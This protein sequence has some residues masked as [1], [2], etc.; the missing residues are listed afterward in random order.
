MDKKKPLFSKTYIK[1]ETGYY[2]SK[3]KPIEIFEIEKPA[4]T[5][6]EY[7]AIANQPL[8]DSKTMATFVEPSISKS[9]YIS[10]CKKIMEKY[11]V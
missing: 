6:D 11:E 5:L 1:P 7:I 4:M 2:K 8:F 9:E 10:K 3:E